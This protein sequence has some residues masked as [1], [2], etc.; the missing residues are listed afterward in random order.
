MERGESRESGRHL[1]PEH[2][3]DTPDRGMREIRPYEILSRLAD[4]YKVGHGG[5]GV[6]GKDS[7]STTIRGRHTRNSIWWR[8]K[9][10]KTMVMQTSSD[11]SRSS[12][13][14]GRFV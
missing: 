14:P 11:T 8:K 1:I 10:K 13:L 7:G 9:L 5:G 6:P 12:H 2:F 3:G 4:L